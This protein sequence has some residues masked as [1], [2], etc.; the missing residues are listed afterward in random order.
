MIDFQFISSGSPVFDLSYCF[1]SGGSG[2]D[3]LKLDQFL[4]IYH[5]SLS[6]T[7]KVF[8]LDAEKI[9]SFNTLLQDW[10]ENCKFGFAMALMLLRAK[11][12]DLKIVPD[13]FGT[14]DIEL[15]MKLV[16]ELKDQFNQAIRDLVLHM[17]NNDFF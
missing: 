7:L 1:Y 16:P 15:L 17:Y 13:I 2:R 4:K 8:G 11:A 9:Y 10:K 6:E 14:Q 12:I 5:V 3:W